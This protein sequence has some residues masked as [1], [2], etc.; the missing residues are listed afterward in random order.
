MNATHPGRFGEA[1]R[2]IAG[3]TYEAEDERGRFTVAFLISEP[4]P[5]REG[6]GGEWHCHWRIESGRG[7]REGNGAGTDSLQALQEALRGLA[8]QISR[9]EAKGVLKARQPTEAAPPRAVPREASHRRTQGEMRQLATQLDTLQR[10][11]VALEAKIL[12]ANRWIAEHR[13]GW[14]REVA[15]ANGAVAAAKTE[16]AHVKQQLSRAQRT[17]GPL[18]ECSNLHILRNGLEKDVTE[19]RTS[20]SRL[21]EERSRLDREVQE[22]RREALAVAGE[23]LIVERKLAALEAA[24]ERTLEH[25]GCDACGAANSP[26][27]RLCKECGEPVRPRH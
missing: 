19:L 5:P 22:S 6:L 26:E 3:R 17:L 16:L 13:A 27:R 23:R 1:L 20:L 11:N 14:G 7:Q 25:I 21:R 12:N 24:A 10:T 9:A 15:Q 18:V 8:D 2:P 4:T